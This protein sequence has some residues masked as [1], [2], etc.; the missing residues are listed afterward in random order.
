MANFQKPKFEKQSITLICDGDLP[1]AEQ[2][3]WFVVPLTVEQLTECEDLIDRGKRASAVRL[4]FQYGCCGWDG[5][6]VD[7]EACPFR[8]QTYPTVKDKHLRLTPD[9]LRLIPAEWQFEIGLRVLD[10]SR[11]SE[12]EKN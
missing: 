9:E 3:K 1:E 11:L 10:I 6:T 8:G 5:L 7:G 2:T 12:Q 4:A